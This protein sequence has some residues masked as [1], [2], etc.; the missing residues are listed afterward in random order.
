M[1]EIRKVLTVSASHLP[2][3]LAGAIAE[4]SLDPR[5]GLLLHGYYGFLVFARG[6][7]PCYPESVRK[8]LQYASGALDCS[9]VLFDSDGDVLDGFATYGDYDT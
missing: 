7:H 6:D 9:F 1:P 2:V 5:G 4:D 3:E 8:L